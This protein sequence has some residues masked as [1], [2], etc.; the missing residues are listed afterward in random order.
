MI[1]V[2]A[3]VFI[4]APLENMLPAYTAPAIPTPPATVNAPVVVEVD[5]V[6][7]VICTFPAVPPVPACKTIDPP[8]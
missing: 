5:A 6:V 8:L 1:K 2:C 4:S 7:L 3:L